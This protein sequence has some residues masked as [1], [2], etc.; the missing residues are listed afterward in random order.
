[1][2]VREVPSSGGIQAEAGHLLARAVLGD[3]ALKRQLAEMAFN[4]FLNPEVLSLFRLEA[5]NYA[6]PS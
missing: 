1:M 2:F 5:N 4:I 6:S 3:K